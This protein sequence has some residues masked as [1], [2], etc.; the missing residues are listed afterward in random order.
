MNYKLIED[1]NAMMLKTREIIDELS[2]T[3]RNGKIKDSEEMKR[4]EHAEKLAT[5][6][7]SK[8]RELHEFI[9]NI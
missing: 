4:L 1:T 9:A 8:L 2:E 5:E 3:I 6:I 7:Y